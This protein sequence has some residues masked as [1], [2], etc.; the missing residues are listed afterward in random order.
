MVCSLEQVGEGTYSPEERK[1]QL[2]EWASVA[3]S[4]GG[5]VIRPKLSERVD[6]G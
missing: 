6:S 5:Q 1:G 2:A 4:E 3:L